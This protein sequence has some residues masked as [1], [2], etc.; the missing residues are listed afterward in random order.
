M[1]NMDR[2]R[3]KS[4]LE[5]ADAAVFGEAARLLSHALGDHPVLLGVRGRTGKLRFWGEPK[6][7]RRPP[8][9]PTAEFPGIGAALDSGLAT[10][11]TK[12]EAARFG[13]QR[14]VAVPFADDEGPNCVCLLLDTGEDD[15]PDVDPSCAGTAAGM[16]VSL[17]RERQR[18]RARVTELEQTVSGFRALMEATSDAVKIVDLDG[19]VRAW[20]HGCETLYGFR[21]QEA[22][23]HVLPHVPSTERPRAVLDF[24]RIASLGVVED[25]EIVATRKD[26]S[27]VS[28]T[29]TAVPLL[30]S[31]GLPAGV[32]T[33]VRRV[34]VDSR[35]DQMQGDFLS[36]VSQELKNP[37][38]AVLGFAQLLARPEIA[39]DPHKRARTVRAL[40]SRAQQMAAVVDDLLLA[41][42]IE[43]G[44]LRLRREPADLATLVTETV[45]RFE[46]F[47]PK[48]RFLIDVDTRMGPVPV[49]S[50]RVEQALTNLLSNAV[51]YSPGAQEVRVGVMPDG[52][53]AAISVS[54]KGEGI[55][56]A[57]L[58]RVF[59]R[60]YKGTPTKGEPGAGLGLYLVRMIAE[61]HEGNVTAVSKS[62]KGST[63]T[64][65]LPLEG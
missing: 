50:R 36:L 32:M 47:Q 59:D 43:R 54:D 8:S 22:I 61:A 64:I 37:L 55:P 25:R 10:P 40:E 3:P 7:G 27:R 19:R 21:A 11:L 30:D 34:E 56:G 14:A 53:F 9:A 41:S 15:L 62:G 26:G 60:F 46:Q 49:D 4:S 17:L 33:I 38:T 5:P 31:E 28:A 45:S 52:G 1:P 63:F 58:E 39:E 6:G 65:R 35:L 48:H 44:D 12:D 20:N 51:K 13:S 57:D 42:R 23:G 24:R 29:A 16:A 18:L 2:E